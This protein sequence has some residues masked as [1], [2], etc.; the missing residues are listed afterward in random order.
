MKVLCH[1]EGARL[2]R[3]DIPSGSLGAPIG[4]GRSPGGGAT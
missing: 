1:L 4:E 3:S 2:L